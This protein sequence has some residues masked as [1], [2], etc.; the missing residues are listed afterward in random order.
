MA[1]ETVKVYTPVKRVP[2]MIGKAQNGQKLPFGP[3]TLPQIVAGIVL[4]V[5]TAVLAMALPVNPA[6][7]AITGV[8]VMVVVVFTVGLVPYT[9]VRLT[10]RIL[11]IG[12]LILVRAPVSASGMPVTAESARQTMYVEESVV[13]ILPDRPTRAAQPRQ[14]HIIAGN[15]LDKW[16]ALPA[17][18]A[19]G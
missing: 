19:A 5:F 18:A 1:T 6:V 17:D 14:A 7:T 12:R 15:V 9:G 13:V 16:K 3:Y 10:S 8:C 4:I 11:W 2:I